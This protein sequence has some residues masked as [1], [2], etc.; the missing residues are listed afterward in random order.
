MSQYSVSKMAKMRRNRVGEDETD[1]KTVDEVSF[2]HKSKVGCG[3][4]PKEEI[5]SIYLT[6]MQKKGEEVLYGDKFDE[7]AGIKMSNFISQRLQT[8]I[9]KHH[10][11][12][13]G[14]QKVEIEEVEM[15]GQNKSIET[16]SLLVRDPGLSLSRPL[17]PL[18][19]SD[20][21]DQ[22]YW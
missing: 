14:S 16:G 5:G 17:A 6:S 19:I 3:Q 10:K 11:P 2:N 22:R 21:I 12:K 20:C 7:I 1:T 13:S 18:Q 15:V 4:K 8:F 9:N